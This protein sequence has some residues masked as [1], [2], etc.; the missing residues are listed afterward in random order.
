MPSLKVGETWIARENCTVKMT[1]GG[2]YVRFKDGRDDVT[3][4]E[5]DQRDF[6]MGDSLCASH[7]GCDFDT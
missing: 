5:G 4:K 1:R 3:L 2:A 6:V 7:G